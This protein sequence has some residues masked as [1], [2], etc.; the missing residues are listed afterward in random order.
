VATAASPQNELVEWTTPAGNAKSSGPW[1]SANAGNGE[2][3]TP[4]MKRRDNVPR[5]EKFGAK[6]CGTP[7]T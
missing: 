3:A 4:S 5:N 2:S 6:S 1:R 7:D